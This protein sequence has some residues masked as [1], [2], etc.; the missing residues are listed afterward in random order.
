[1]LIPMLRDKYATWLITPL[2]IGLVFTG[3]VPISNANAAKT[4]PI[5]TPNDAKTWGLDSLGSMMSSFD[6]QPLILDIN[7]NFKVP[8]PSNLSDFVKNRKAA[9]VL[10]KALF[11]DMQVGSDGIQACASCHFQAG[12]DIRSKNQVSTQGRRV[13]DRRDG[14]IKGYFFSPADPDTTFE[15]VFGRTWAPNFK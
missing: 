1:M 13:L 6:G 2:V 15:T 9:L 11:W 10:G 3:L 7:K 12:A 5:K 4:F 8:L 14:E